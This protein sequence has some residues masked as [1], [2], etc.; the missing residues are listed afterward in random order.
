MNGT[1]CFFKSRTPRPNEIQDCPHIILTSESNWD[2]SSLEFP[3][4]QMEEEESRF[5]IA[6]ATISVSKPVFRLFDD[7]LLDNISPI[8]STSTLLPALISSVKV[9]DPSVN[10]A[11]NSKQRHSEITPENLASKWKIGLQ[12]AR[13]TLKVT[14]QLGIRHAI[15]PLK[16]RYRTDHMSLSYR[17]LS[18]R[19]YSDTLFAKVTSLKGNTCAQVFTTNDTGYIRV[20]PMHSKSQAG[21]ALQALADD[22]GIP[23]EIVVDG[24]AEQVGPKSEFMKAVN[25]LRTKIKPTEPYSPWQNQAE[26]AIRELKKR[27]KHR[28]SV[29]KIPRRLWDY[30]LVYESEI[31]SRT[32]RGNDKRTGIERM[33][34]DS[35]DISEWVDFDFYDP[36]WFW[37]NPDNPEN[38]LIGRWLGV[39][40]RVGSDMCYWILKSNGHVLARTTVQHVPEID[41][42]PSEG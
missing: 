37:D 20:H 22:V 19:M 36:V 21:E 33:T 32:A 34:G 1:I 7:T 17:R 15:H 5:G 13:D 18:T 2:P 16:R 3:R 39:A 29:K 31:M 25:Y 4:G 28:M 9:Q 40:H 35:P 24:A 14:T 6:S 41:L 8:F 30:G 38:P 27:W 42:R 10:A 12:A 11:V 26:S 23:A